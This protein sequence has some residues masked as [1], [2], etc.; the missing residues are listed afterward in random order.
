MKFIYERIIL[1]SPLIIL[2]FLLEACQ[3][4]GEKIILENPCLPPCW[5]NITPGK[6]EQEELVKILESMPDINKKTV[7]VLGSWNNFDSV[8]EATLISKP[9]IN[10]Y[11]QDGKVVLIFI[12]GKLGLT[13]F[14]AMEHFG[15]PDVITAARTLGPSRIL[16]G[17]SPLLYISAMIPEIGIGFGFDTRDILMKSDEEIKPDSKITEFY[18]YDPEYFETL[19]DRGLFTMGNDYK[20]WRSSS[21]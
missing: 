4:D 16:I 17:D 9:I 3:K 10:F 13:Y 5:R 11:I 2:L 19:L 21:K 12:S 20:Y 15:D 1:L 14:E 7:H 8:V 6:T 18:Y